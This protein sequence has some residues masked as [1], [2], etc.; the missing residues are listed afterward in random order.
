MPKQFEKNGNL[1]QQ[2]KERDFEFD[3]VSNLRIA[4]K[5][6]LPESKTGRV[7]HQS[8]IIHKID[9]RKLLSNEI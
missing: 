9:F 1:L 7:L 8:L 6:L 2:N 3:L 4:K 5:K